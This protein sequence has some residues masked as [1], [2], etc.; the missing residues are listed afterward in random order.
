MFLKDKIGEN[1]RYWKGGESVFIEAQTGTGKT[2]FVLE[3]LVPY[4]T[5]KGQEVLFLSNRFLLKEQVKIKTA[6]KQG[7]PLNDFD[8]VRDVEEF[9][10]ITVTTYQKLQK[11]CQ[12]SGEVILAE[13][14]KKRYYCVVYDEC[15]YIL[16]DSA[17]NP[18]IFYLLLFIKSYTGL[19]IFLSATMDGL[20][21]F[22]LDWKYEN[23]IN[24]NSRHSSTHVTLYEIIQPSTLLVG[25]RFWAWIYKF[26]ERKRQTEVKIFKDF[27]ELI[28]LIN[29]ENEEKWIVFMGNK[30]KMLEYKK[31]I[32]VPCD[33]L[34]ADNSKAKEMQG[35]IDEIRVNECFPRKVLLTTKILDNGISIKDLKVK[36]IVIDTDSRT[37]FLQMYGRKRILSESDTFKLFIPQKSASYFSCLLKL[38]VEP[39][40][41]FLNKRFPTYELLR[42]L[43]DKDSLQISLRF[44]AEYEKELV[45]NPAGKFKLKMEKQFLENMVEKMKDDPWAF[46]KVQMEWLKM[47]DEFSE[48]LSISVE[49]YKNDLL[50]ISNFVRNYEGVRLGKNEQEKFRKSFMNEL[51]I[52]DIFIGKNGRIPGKSAINKFF[53]NQKIPYNIKANKIS[54]KGEETV[55]IIE[56]REDS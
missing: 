13:K 37:E 53:E 56:R 20:Q 40:L 16:Q 38:R 44:Y 9:D 36:N 17:F 51:S 35:L 50:E 21:D 46:A 39:S 29:K 3:Q 30:G 24:W 52:R 45:C 8:L 33:L 19:D 54:K 6:E 26:P 18:E 1:Y 7:L 25:N 48:D 12:Y 49:N 41:N 22:I 43:Q 31:K 28:P 32:K 47:E 2:T 11:V 10:G 14:I 27:D 55:W 42:L 4:A 23:K 34:N 5:E 15:H